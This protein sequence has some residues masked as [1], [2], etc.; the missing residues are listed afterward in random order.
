MSSFALDLCSLGLRTLLTENVQ[1]RNHFI[2]FNIDNKMG[3]E[4]IPK[5]I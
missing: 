3:H 4:S 5:Y 1:F 2:L